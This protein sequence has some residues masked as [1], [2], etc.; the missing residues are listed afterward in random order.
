MILSDNQLRE[1]IDESNL[2]V[3]VLDP[4]DTMFE[5][6]GRY[7]QPASVEVTLDNHVLRSTMTEGP[8]WDDCLLYEDS[9]IKPGEFML[10]STREKV[11]V[12]DDLIGFVHGKSSLGRKGLLIHITAGLLDP[13]FSGTITLEL[14]NVS[15][16]PVKLEPGM[17]IGQLT[18]QQLTSAAWK[19][20]GSPGLGSH[21]Q[22]Q[23][24]TTESKG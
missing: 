17:K 8:S 4:G 20:Y 7:V 5:W 11:N 23:S 6:M 19:P 1:K 16:E 22:N 13:G 9:W 3:P 24:G 15:D 10:A 18:F 21:Y 14:K 2:V 12:P